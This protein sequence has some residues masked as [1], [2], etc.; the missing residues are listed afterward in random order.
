VLIIVQHIA[1][2]ISP[3]L[4]QILLYFEFIEIIS[5]CSLFIAYKSELNETGLHENSKQS[6]PSFRKSKHG[7]VKITEFFKNNPSDKMDDYLFWLK[8]IINSVRLNSEVVYAC[9]DFISSFGFIFSFYD[10]YTRIWNS[11]NFR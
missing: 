3:N 7:K 8:E 11:L 5:R 2:K 9:K 6:S 1:I 4:V 10:K